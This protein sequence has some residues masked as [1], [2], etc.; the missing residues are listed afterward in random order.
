MYEVLHFQGQDTLVYKVL[1]CIFSVRT[2]WCMKYYTAFSESGHTGVC[3]II[4]PFQ[5]QDTLVYEVLFSQ[6]QDPLA[7]EVFSVLGCTGI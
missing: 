3:S 5:G 6:W 7:Y 1:Y 2:H 4:L